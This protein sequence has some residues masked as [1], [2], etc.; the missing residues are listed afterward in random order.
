MDE[1]VR[2]MCGRSSGEMGSRNSWLQALES[3]KVPRCGIWVVSWR[4]FQPRALVGMCVGVVTWT[5]GVR[6]EETSRL[7]RAQGGG[8]S[9]M[10]VKGWKLSMVRRGGGPGWLT[11]ND[12]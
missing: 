3:W 4:S 5:Y 12:T 1:K 11:K 2:H 6:R 9:D 10:E 8:V 7:F